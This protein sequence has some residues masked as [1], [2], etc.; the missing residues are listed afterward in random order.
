MA[1]NLGS[2]FSFLWVVLLCLG[3]LGATGVSPDPLPQP[4]PAPYLRLEEGFMHRFIAQVNSSLAVEDPV[5]A[6]GLPG[7][8]LRYADTHDMDWRHLFTLAWQESDF[9]CHATNRRDKGGAFGPFQI[10]RLWEPVIGDPRP[11]YFDPELAVERVVQ[12]MKYFQETERYQD[13]IERRFRNP[14]LCLYNSGESGRV[15]MDYCREVG[16]KLALV[17]EA[18]ELYRTPRNASQ[19]TPRPRHTQRT[20]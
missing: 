15:N 4:A 14:L 8:I 19:R 2:L 5:C 18:W 12:V 13:L 3:V 6:E 10:R 20:G 17:R 1:G 7:A 11:R 16:R 9:D